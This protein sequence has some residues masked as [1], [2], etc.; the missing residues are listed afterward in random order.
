MATISTVI[1]DPVKQ[2]TDERGIPYANGSLYSY[3]A[4]TGTLHPTY[5][6]AA[7]S[8]PN[9]NP[10]QLDAAGRA[11]VF[12]DQTIYRF[13]LKN[14]LGQTIWDQDNIAGSIWP[15]A[16]RGSSIKTPLANTNGYGHSFASLLNKADT[17]THALF[18]GVYFAIPTIGTGLA[19]VVEFATVY[20]AGAPTSGATNLYALH[21]AGTAR[22]DGDVRL[23]TGQVALGG[24]STA[25]LGTIGGSGP[26]NPAQAAWQKLLQADG[27]QMFIP[28]WI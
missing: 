14:A 27:T 23:G 19:A 9:T 2:F 13:T 4:G 20:I 3:D 11:I 1:S 5:A 16:V 21:V 24:G 10:V 8:T 25:T 18:A 22:F 28:Y 6:D 7:L 26:S 12:M 17:G 15:G